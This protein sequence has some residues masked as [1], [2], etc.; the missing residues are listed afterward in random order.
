MALAGCT[1]MAADMTGLLQRMLPR[2]DATH[3]AVCIAVSKFGL[4]PPPDEAAVA[5]WNLLNQ[6]TQSIHF[7]T[8]QHSA[9][10]ISGAQS[11]AAQMH[12]DRM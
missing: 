6:N 2:L 4:T 3:L 8:L 11:F 9:Q 5:K 1:Q 12:W 10:I 7:D